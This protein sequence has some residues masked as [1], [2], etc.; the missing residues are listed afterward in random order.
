MIEAE[1]LTK[2]YGDTTAVDDVS[3][4]LHPGMVTGFLGPNGAGKTTTM[5]LVLGLDRATSGAVRINGRVYSD[6]AVPLR[7]VG[8]LL[9][10]GAVHKGRSAYDHLR[11][12]AESNAIPLARVGEVLR[13]VGL[14]SVAR[15][16]VRSFSLGM[17]QRLGIAAALLGDPGIMLFDEPIN[18]LDPQGILWVRSLLRS[19]A[20]EGRTILVSSH[21]MNEMAQTADRLLV[22]GRGKIIADTTVEELVR[23]NST[24]TV[25]VRTPAATD[26]AG[27]LAGLGAVVTAAPDGAL[28]VAGPDAAT[29]GELAAA[30]GLPLHELTPVRASLEEAFMHLT[31]G[32]VEFEGQARREAPR[33]DRPAW[34]EGPASEYTP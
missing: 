22:I 8:A 6:L 13:T 14:D 9:D 30:A 17:G 16:K 28:L 1:H 18:G 31:E 26:L 12:L 33:A 20:G 27:R 2:R 15:K 24:Q 7:E 21:L 23:A 34:A 25:R 5:R 11:F 32:S 29:I 19:L 10:A 4:V 3:F